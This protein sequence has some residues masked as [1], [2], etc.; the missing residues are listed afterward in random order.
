MGRDLTV[1]RSIG[2]VRL[3]NRKPGI[4]LYSPFAAAQI[5]EGENYFEAR[6]LEPEDVAAHVRAGSLVGFLTEAPG[7]FILRF[8]EGEP[9]ADEVAGHP[10][11]IAL[12]LEVRDETL[13]VRDV[14]DLC[15][16]QRECPAAQRLATEDGY[17][18]VLLLSKRP[19]SGEL[20]DDQEILV[21]LDRR[22]ALPKSTW[23]GV[24]TLI[25]VSQPAR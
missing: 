7:T 16:W 10:F 9:E 14:D 21:F 12:P 24:P 19:P 8:F 23:Q 25:V 15:S 18:R 13:C 20:G 1:R 3:A 11:R 6:Y 5:Q 22:K 4:L 2:V 17:Y